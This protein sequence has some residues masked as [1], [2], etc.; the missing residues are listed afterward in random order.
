MRQFITLH[1]SAKDITGQRFGRLVSLGPIGVDVFVGGSR[2][3]RWLCKCDCGA[4]KAVTGF[5]LRNGNTSSCGCL[6]AE[7]RKTS[8]R[9]AVTRHGKRKTPEYAAWRSALKR[10]HSP[11]EKSYRNYGARGIAVCERWQSFEN[12]YADMGPRPSPDHSLDRIDNDGNYEPANCRW[13]T[14]SEQ[15][16]NTR[17]NFII[18]AFGRTAP[19]GAFVSSKS[20]G[21]QL[22]WQRMRRGWEP[23]RALTEPPKGGG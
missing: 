20:N 19:L 14:K 7:A 10:C 16:L 15:S 9:L 4:E 5:K 22:A 11:R 21:F 17:S 23:E 1:K 12:F 6:Q 13:A 3:V 2:N 18:T 8:C